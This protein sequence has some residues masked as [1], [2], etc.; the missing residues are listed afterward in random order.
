MSKSCKKL[1]S[2]FSLNLSCQPE[3]FGR[4]FPFA[5]KCFQNPTLC[6]KPGLKNDFFHWKL[7]YSIRNFDGKVWLVSGEVNAPFWFCYFQATD[8]SNRPIWF[9]WIAFR[10]AI[11]Q[12]QL[13]RH[14]CKVQSWGSC[15]CFTC[16][17]DFTCWF[18]SF[19]RLVIYLKAGWE[20][21][22]SVVVWTSV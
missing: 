12:N 11:N 15:S 19:P 3:R 5:A 14:G 1:S 20:M 4:T 8:P 18:Q 6:W 16:S 21:L 10:N 2:P 9:Q 7:N 22:Q 13:E 17:L